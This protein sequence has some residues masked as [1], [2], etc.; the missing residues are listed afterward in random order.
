MSNA[1]GATNRRRFLTDTWPE[2]ITVFGK[3]ILMPITHPRK[4][5]S[6]LSRLLLDKVRLTRNAD[7]QVKAT[8][9]RTH[10]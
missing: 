7:W 4:S 10:A 6:V 2:E 5:G 3:R 1:A 8:T 9:G